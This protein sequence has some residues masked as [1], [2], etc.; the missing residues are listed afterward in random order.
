MCIVVFRPVGVLPQVEKHCCEWSNGA[1]VSVLIMCVNIWTDIGFDSGYCVNGSLVAARDS[2]LRRG[3]RV[4]GNLN[5]LY[6][7]VC[8]GGET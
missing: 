2:C 5:F 7:G 6:L 1:S 8:V 3:G 4:G